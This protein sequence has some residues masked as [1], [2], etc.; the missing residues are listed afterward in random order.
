MSI[1]RA[2]ADDS[3]AFDIDPGATARPRPRIAFW[4]RLLT[5]ELR[6][7]V[8]WGD[9][10]MN[11]WNAR[12]DESCSDGLMPNEMSASRHRELPSVV[13]SSCNQLP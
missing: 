7:I 11:G 6:P 4:Y 9:P 12:D 13:R 10:A 1:Y 2:G 5:S 8:A 3:A